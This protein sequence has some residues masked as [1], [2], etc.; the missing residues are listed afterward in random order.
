MP[1]R[2]PQGKLHGT[3]F[4]HAPR[5]NE[6]YILMLPN[7]QSQ[8]PTVHARQFAE[9]TTSKLTQSLTTLMGGCQNYGPFLGP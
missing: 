7:S 3:L 2:F 6:H 5:G 9:A 1:Q 8:I 4:S